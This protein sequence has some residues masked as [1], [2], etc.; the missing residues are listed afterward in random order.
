MHDWVKI[1]ASVPNKEAIDTILSLG[2]L[3]KDT[4][5]AFY[6]NIDHLKY[7]EGV[8]AQLLV[9]ARLGQEDLDED[10]LETAMKAINEVVESLE[11]D[12]SEKDIIRSNRAAER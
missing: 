4:L 9:L 6:N 12:S 8:V 7:V 2:Y 1:A 10:G 5:T 3:K 11:S